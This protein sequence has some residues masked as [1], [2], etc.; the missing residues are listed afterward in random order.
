MLQSPPERQAWFSAAYELWLSS[1]EKALEALATANQ[2]RTL[3]G[4]DAAAFRTLIVDERRLVTREFTLLLGA[5]LL[6][7]SSSRSQYFPG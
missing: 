1:W 7:N 6:E 3:S 5:G 4:H 2:A